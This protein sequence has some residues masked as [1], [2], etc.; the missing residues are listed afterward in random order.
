[1]RAEFA[2]ELAKLTDSLR[3]AEGMLVAFAVVDDYPTRESIIAELRLRLED[4]I[5]LREIHL[6]VEQPDLYDALQAAPDAA[7]R[8]APNS[9]RAL[10]QA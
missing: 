2:V 10:R 6:S 3:I 8:A 7:G 4:E 5:A 1:M 9:Y